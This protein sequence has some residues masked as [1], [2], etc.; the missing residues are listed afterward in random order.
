MK[1]RVFALV[2]A[3][4]FPATIPAAGASSVEAQPTIAISNFGEYRT[5]KTGESF[6]TSQTAAGRTVVVTR[7]R[8]V[9]R[10]DVIIGQLGRDFG[11]EIDLH[12]FGKGPVRLTIRTVHPPLTNPDT[13]RTTRISEY[14]QDITRRRNVFFGFTFTHLWELAEGEWVRQFFYRGRLLA[15]Q[16][17]RV[18]IPMN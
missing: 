2:L 18:V 3:A 11:V 13:G 6:P 16:R 9:K 4:G 14:D 7:T 17:F 10:T 1:L 12:G 5:I 8:L 15:Q